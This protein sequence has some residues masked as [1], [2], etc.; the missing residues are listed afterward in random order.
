MSN[1]TLQYP[2]TKDWDKGYIVINGQNR[3]N[4]ILYNSPKDRSTT[5]YA[6]YLVSVSL[7]RYLEEDEHVDHIDD[8]K[9]NDELSNLQILTQ[10][11]NTRKE[12]R[13]KGRLLSEIKCPSC[14]TLFTRRRGLTQ[15]VPS[16]KGKVT[17]CSTRCSYDL[18]ARR[19]T[20]QERQQIS[21][22]SLLRVFR[23]HA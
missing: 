1:F 11:E 6:R 9:T 22:R 20:L 23:S 3:K 16:L 18:T 19:L 7:S 10:T 13:R 17:C 15:A 8:D 12:S 2:Y 4:V 21:E 5:S 14:K